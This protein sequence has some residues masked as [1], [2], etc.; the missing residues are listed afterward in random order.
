MGMLLLL[1]LFIYY[2]RGQHIKHIY[3]HNKVFLT[4]VTDHDQLK[5][6]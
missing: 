3:L 4:D 5:F 2:A 1:L 6:S